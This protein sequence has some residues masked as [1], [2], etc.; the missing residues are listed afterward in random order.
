MPPGVQP[1]EVQFFTRVNNNSTNISINNL[2]LQWE[3]ILL[4]YFSSR[5]CGF[6]GI[7]LKADRKMGQSCSKG[8]HDENKTCFRTL[9]SAQGPPALPSE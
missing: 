7:Y 5:F 3:I 8:S 4:F 1:K 6:N 2:L 9:A